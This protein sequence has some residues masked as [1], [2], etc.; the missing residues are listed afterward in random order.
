MTKCHK[1]NFVNYLPSSNLE[2]NAFYFQI[3]TVAYNLFLLFKQ[4]LDKNLQKH[5]V[6]TI[7]YKLYNIAGKVVSHAREMILKVNEQFTKLLQ[8]IRYKA[9]KESLE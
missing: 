1:A 3:G 8:T 6:K 9:Y 7:R 5:T 4:I 2:A